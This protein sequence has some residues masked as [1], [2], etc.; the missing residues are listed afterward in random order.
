MDPGL[1][2][3]QQMF[4]T[5][6]GNYSF[7]LAD[8]SQPTAS[9]SKK[10]S[11]PK[12][13][14][15]IDLTKLNGAPKLAAAATS[16][17]LTDL[18]ASEQPVTIPKPSNDAA[19]LDAKSKRDAILKHADAYTNARAH[20]DQLAA[21]GLGTSSSGKQFSVL[22][23]VVT[24]MRDR[25]LKGESQALSVDE[26]LDELGLPHGADSELQNGVTDATRNWLEYE[27]LPNNAKMRLV[28]PKEEVSVSSVS[29][30][31]TSNLLALKTKRQLRDFTLIGTWVAVHC[32]R[33]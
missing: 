9:V 28:D 17:K 6:I 18:A 33:S 15:S 1:R 12:S 19:D 21:L 4:K 22:Q 27:A 20:R 2:K 5:K 24:H 8:S 25:F 13:A 23:K 10:S 3:Q 14:T 26:M 29:F 16:L 11:H 32:I 7:A 30:S 31:L